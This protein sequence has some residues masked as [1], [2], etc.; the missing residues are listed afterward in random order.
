MRELESLPLQEIIAVVSGGSDSGY[1]T[2]SGLPN[3]TVVYHPEPLDAEVGRAIGAA[4]TRADMLLFVSGDEPIESHKLAKFLAAVQRGAD[5]ALCDRT[6]ALGR[7]SEW[8]NVSRIQSFLNRS[9]GRADLGAA[10][11]AEV[12]YAISRRALDA[13]GIRKLANPPRAHAAAISGGMKV[14]LCPGVPVMNRDKLRELAE[15]PDNPVTIQRI[16]DYYE[17]LREAQDRS[18][19]RLCLVDAVRRRDMLGGVP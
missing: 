6:S 1:H 9:L 8:D 15:G 17:A 16:G 7:F 12:P 10:T 19:K 2:V 3:V 11:M 14:V 18:G 5:I 13:V 4:M